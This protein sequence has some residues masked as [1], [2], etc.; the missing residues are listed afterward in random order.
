MT[1][2]LVKRGSLDAEIDISL[3]KDDVRK[4]REKTA[5]HKPKREAWNRFFHRNPQKEPT[6][7]T[8]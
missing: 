2:I 5:I 1:G 3:R 6:L 4:H 8:P 7:W